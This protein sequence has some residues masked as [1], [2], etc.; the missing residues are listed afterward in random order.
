MGGA[1]Q[2]SSGRAQS[3]IGGASG[4]AS[5]GPESIVA[6]G[7]PHAA[8]AAAIQSAFLIAAAYHPSRKA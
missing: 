3:T 6:P 1:L 7:P 4:P 5:L 2:Q 8:S